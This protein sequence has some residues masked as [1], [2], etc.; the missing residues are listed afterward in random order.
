MQPV[1]VPANDHEPG[2]SDDGR[3]IEDMIRHEPG[4]DSVQTL[5]TFHGPDFGSQ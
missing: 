4:R 3:S 5:A 1:T 2:M